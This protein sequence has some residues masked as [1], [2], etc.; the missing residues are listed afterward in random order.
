MTSA[1]WTKG[2]SLIE[3][4]AVLAL[5]SGV[6]LTLTQLRGMQHQQN[7]QQSLL[8]TIDHIQTALYGHFK[9]NYEFPPSLAAIELT[10]MAVTPWGENLSLLHENDEVSIV[11]P[12][13]NNKVMAWLQARLPMAQQAEHKLLVA[14]PRPVQ[15]L[16]A[17]FA[18]H[19]VAVAGRPE[20]NEMEA[21]LDMNGFAVSD[22]SELDAELAQF[23]QLTVNEAVVT[24][25]TA[26]EVWLT[27]Q[28]TAVNADIQWLQ[29]DFIQVES[30]TAEHAEVETLQ[31]EQLS[32]SILSS[33]QLQ[34]NSL[35]SAEL[36]AE[37]ITTGT[38]HA[39]Q[40]NAEDF[41]TEGASFNDVH[42]RLQE[43]ELAWLTC[44]NQGGCK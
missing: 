23:E 15:A 5:V 17:D 2:F 31:V 28:L 6:L 14:V 8:D 36:N 19:R 11:I 32:A 18:L 42:R 20:L 33:E 22:F 3:F 25:L 44:V 39:G 30:F 9:S 4:V 40:V 12:T 29:A 16:S 35:T 7:L 27:E 1:R 38:L 41:V 10:A 13:P 43:L 24:E 34:T 21:N 26:D 37:H